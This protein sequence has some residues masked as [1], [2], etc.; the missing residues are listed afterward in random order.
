MGSW[1]DR[2][3]PENEQFWKQTGSGVAWRTLILT[4]ISLVFSFSTWF[5]ISAVVVRLPKIGFTFDTMQLFWLAAMP[6]LA[7]GTLRLI[8]SF[9]VPIFGTRTV[10]S[11]ATFLKVIPMVML[12]FAVMDPST[13]FW[14]F[15]LIAF[16]CG[17]GGGDFSSFMPSTSLFFPKR[18]QGVALGIQAGVG[19][20]G[21]SL[22]QFVTPWIIGAGAITGIA[23]APQ[24]F[25]KSADVPPADIWLQNAALWYV[26]V[27]VV[28]GILCWM[29]LRSVPVKAS[30]RQQLDILPNKH[31]WFC[32]IIYVMTF[33]SFAGLSA[34]FPLMI[35]KIYGGFPGAPDPL[36]YAFYGP[37]VGSVIRII[38]GAP[39]DRFGG[40]IITQISGLGLILGSL[41]LIF[42]GLLTPTSLDQFPMFLGVMLFLFL[43][44]GIGNASTFRQFPI[45]FA[46]SP[47]QGAGVLGWSGAWAAYGPFIFSSL[48]GTSIAKTGDVRSF[49]WGACAFFALASILN[50]VYYTKPGAERGDW[51]NK[52][53][54]WWDKAKS[55]WQ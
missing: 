52:W 17:F 35:S 11:V 49:F 44:A 3:E 31:T 24:I 9:L 50:W 33:G 47:R 22:T 8:H 40:A 5:V 48:I 55:S 14:M 1:L 32:T 6:G 2:W 4:T 10:V 51:G 27:L 36:R 38:M 34:A 45:A 42:G 43:M 13:P 18:L 15:M 20:F 54:T 12:A 21:V 26:P 53:G 46:Y 30:F 7:G 23:A 37:L 39:S 16:L 28:M 41:A 29:W 25:R 19:N